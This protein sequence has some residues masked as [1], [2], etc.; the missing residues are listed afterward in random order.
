MDDIL[1]I[2]QVEILLGNDRWSVSVDI[3]DPTRPPLQD[4]PV[5]RD[6]LM[7]CSTFLDSTVF[8]WVFTEF[9]S[10]KS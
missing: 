6:R 4:R 5:L 3:V 8:S 10:S 9:F 2:A 1:T 7:T